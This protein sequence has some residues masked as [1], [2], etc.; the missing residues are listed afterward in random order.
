MHIVYVTERGKHIKE[1]RR[2]LPGFGD[3][4]KTLKT[5]VKQE[6]LKKKIKGLLECNDTSSPHTPYIMAFID[7]KNPW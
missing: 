5:K 7:K 6:V 3:V 1:Y 2:C 4:H